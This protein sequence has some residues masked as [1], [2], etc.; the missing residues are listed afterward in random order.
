MGDVRQY[1]IDQRVRNTHSVS[2]SGY[3]IAEWR[4]PDSQ[5]AF[6]LANG[7]TI[8][9]YY[10]AR[11]MRVDDHAPN[12]SFFFQRH[13]CGYVVI[14]RV[15]QRI[16][17]RHAYRYHAGPRSGA[18]VPRAD[19]RSQPAQR[20]IAFNDIRT[21]L[22]A[23]YALFGNCNSLHTSLRRS[24]HHP[25]RGVRRAVRSADHQPRARPEYRSKTPGRGRSRSTT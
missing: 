20:E 5:L 3:R 11:G 22:Q 12:L 24:A 7:F 17:A 19:L 16:F 8:A 15:A 6:T 23:L 9:E 25:D 2:I 14:G 18:Q 4:Q 1:F 10:L 21:T 13:G